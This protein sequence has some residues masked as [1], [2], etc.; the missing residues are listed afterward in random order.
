LF[1]PSDDRVRRQVRVKAQGR[2]LRGPWRNITDLKASP[3][4][5]FV[6]KSQVQAR[7]LGS[8]P[9]DLKVLGFLLLFLPVLWVVSAGLTVWVDEPF[10]RG[11][12]AL[13][14]WVKAKIQPTAPS[15]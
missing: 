2:I 15:A 1:L 10:I 11:G 7:F 4:E 13:A 5:G 9:Y 6:V 3:A 8:A 14:R 12:K